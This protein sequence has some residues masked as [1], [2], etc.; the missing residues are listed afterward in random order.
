MVTMCGRNFG[1]DKTE[2][3]KMSLVTVEVAGAPC[4][5]PRQDYINR[6]VCVCVLVCFFMPHVCVFFVCSYASALA[7]AV[8][9]GI[10]FS[11]GLS[12]P[13]LRT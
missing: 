3:F 7:K 11:G 13:L 12:V 10:M 6:C 2:S 4:K 1:F 9:G 8:A 5:L